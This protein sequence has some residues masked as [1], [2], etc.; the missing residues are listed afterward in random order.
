M[1]PRR[2]LV[3]LGCLFVMLGCFFVMLRGCFRHVALQL[4]FANSPYKLSLLRSINVTL[5]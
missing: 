1:V 4:S 2:V 5:V 3:V